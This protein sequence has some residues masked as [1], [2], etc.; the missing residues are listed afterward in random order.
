M[1]GTRTAP[2][3]NSAVS[4]T[5][6]TPAPSPV[7]QQVAA[8]RAGSSVFQ[9]EV[10]T[11]EL[12]L[13]FPITVTDCLSSLHEAHAKTLTLKAAYLSA[14]LLVK[15]ERG[16]FLLVEDDRLAHP[17]LVIPS[18][19]R[20]VT[21]QDFYNNYDGFYNCM[22]VTSGEVWIV[23]PAIVEEVAEGWQLRL[24]GELKL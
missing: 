2:S 23:S 9:Q 11:R 15:A 19:E 8:T 13:T 16:E 1:A 18:M 10:V 14:G 12:K 4:A 21:K 22:K 3:F 5:L 6:P 7:S 20:F 17:L 24:K